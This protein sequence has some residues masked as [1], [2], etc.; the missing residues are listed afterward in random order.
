VRLLAQRERSNAEPEI[1][2]A[3]EERGPPPELAA[4]ARVASGEQHDAAE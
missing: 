2:D 1:G 3:D 4:C